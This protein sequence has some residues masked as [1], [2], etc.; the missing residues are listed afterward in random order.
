MEVLR[1]VNPAE[2]V[3]QVHP[4]GKVCDTVPSLKVF[5]V[6][7]HS[8][9]TESLLATTLLLALESKEFGTLAP[10]YI[11][12][13]DG[14][15]IVPV[16][17]A[18]E[19][20]M[21]SDNMAAMAKVK[22]A[23]DATIIWARRRALLVARPRVRCMKLPSLASALLVVS[24]VEM[25]SGRIRLLR[26]AELPASETAAVSG[27]CPAR[28]EHGTM[29]MRS[30]SGVGRSPGPKRPMDRNQRGPRRWPAELISHAPRPHLS[31]VRPQQPPY[32]DWGER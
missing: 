19:A 7:F 14:A 11:V 30:A 9:A 8:N 24:R 5:A 1:A 22:A 21:P 4:G 26:A 28:V 12:T 31:G 6:M 18:L 2:L 27:P 15:V 32:S 3:C 16:M 29:G 13:I 17:A 20:D 25:Q 23:K 10:S